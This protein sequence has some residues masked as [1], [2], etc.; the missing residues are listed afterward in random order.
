[1]N[2]KE[3][4]SLTPSLHP[5]SAAQ[6][7]DLSPSCPDWETEEW[8]TESGLGTKSHTSVSYVVSMAARKLLRVLPI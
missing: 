8:Q 3:K 6:L 5:P 2:L 1:M 4:S 7:V